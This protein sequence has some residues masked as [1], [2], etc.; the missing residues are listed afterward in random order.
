MK[1]LSVLFF[2]MTALVGTSTAQELRNFSF[3]REPIVSPQF[4]ESQ[5][6]FRLLAPRAYEVRLY[7]SWNADYRS[8]LAMSRDTSGVW[9]A[10][11]P[12]PDPEIY[13]YSFIV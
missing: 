3:G 6:T 11:I 10:T 8:T 2:L 7:G 5:V 13:T 12:L 1:K 9:S 4:T